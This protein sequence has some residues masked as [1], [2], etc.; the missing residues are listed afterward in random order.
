MCQEL[1]HAGKTTSCLALGSP[2]QAEALLWGF[3]PTL[4]VPQA[5][6][7]LLGAQ[8]DGMCGAETAGSGPHIVGSAVPTMSTLALGGA[9]LP[10]LLGAVRLAKAPLPRLH[11]GADPPGY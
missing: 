11:P 4:W 10:G 7:L 9:W 5:L 8:Q 1:G 3:L 6:H 2:A